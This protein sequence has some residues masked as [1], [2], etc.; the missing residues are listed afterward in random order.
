MAKTP[1]VKAGPRV[2][3]RW[4]DAKGILHMTEAPPSSGD[5]STIKSTD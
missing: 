1:A 5:Y 3:Y 2:Y 4:K